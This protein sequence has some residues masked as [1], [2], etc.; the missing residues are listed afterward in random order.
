MKID[1]KFRHSE[2][3]EELTAYVSERLDRL[4]KFELKPARMDVTFTAEKTSHRVDI[5][6]RGDHLELHAH[7]EA[8]T[9]FSGVDQAIDK[10]ARQ[11]AKKKNR[12]QGHQAPK[13]SKVG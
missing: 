5:H 1:F 7:S 9:F 8:D 12:V 3:S 4:E 10:I 2:P 13:A 11:L 6:V